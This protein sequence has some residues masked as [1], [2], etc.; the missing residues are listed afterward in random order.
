MIVIQ[1]E[2]RPLEFI[3]NDDDKAELSQSSVDTYSRFNPVT[4][5]R[6]TDPLEWLIDALLSHMH[7]EVQAALVKQLIVSGGREVNVKY[8]MEC[9]KEGVD[10][11][12]VL[13]AIIE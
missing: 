3:I 13:G 7:P 8:Q 12:L 2:T 5:E 11:K 6:Y 1:R 9:K 10:V 4:G